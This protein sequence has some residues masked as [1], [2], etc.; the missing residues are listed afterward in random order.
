VVAQLVRAPAFAEDAGSNPVHPVVFVEEVRPDYIDIDDRRGVPGWWNTW[1]MPGLWDDGMK[2]PDINR[3]YIPPHIPPNLLDHYQ[4]YLETPDWRFKRRKV[5]KRAKGRCELCT[6]YWDSPDLCT[7]VTFGWSG[8]RT[9]QHVH[10]MTYERLFF[11]RLHDLLAV[12]YTCHA[13]LHPSNDHLA[14]LC[15]KDELWEDPNV[16]FDSRPV[17]ERAKGNY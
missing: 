17:E 7:Q 9:A 16:E 6:A 8:V 4:K 11:E 2:V 13:L 12:C 15:A 3:G 14:E 5:M 10:H 1:G